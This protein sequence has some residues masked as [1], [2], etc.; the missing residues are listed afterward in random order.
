MALIQ[1]T[2]KSNVYVSGNVLN[3]DEK[4][5][6]EVLNK[7]FEA[8]RNKDIAAFFDCYSMDSSSCIPFGILRFLLF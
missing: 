1:L 5:I 2:H 8:M 4:Q 7:S 6:L 3:E